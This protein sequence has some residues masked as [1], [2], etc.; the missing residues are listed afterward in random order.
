[1][2][3]E[4]MTSRWRGKERDHY[5]ISTLSL[6]MDVSCLHGL[7]TG[8]SLIEFETI[9]GIC[10]LGEKQV[11]FD[12]SNFFR[13]LILISPTRILMT[14]IMQK[15]KSGWAREGKLEKVPMELFNSALKFSRCERRGGEKKGPSAG[16]LCFII[17]NGERDDNSHPILNPASRGK[18]FHS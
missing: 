8:K 12:V 5:R 18:V 3:V 14:S 6:K 11:N 4:S 15:T 17:E 7:E 1:L 13:L 10:I 9:M 2:N 16:G